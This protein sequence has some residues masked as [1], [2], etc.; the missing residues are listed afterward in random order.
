MRNWIRNKIHF[1]R[2]ILYLSIDTFW[3]ELCPSLEFGHTEET[4]SRSHSFKHCN[5]HKELEHLSVLCRSRQRIA[6]VTVQQLIQ[7]KK[8][9]KKTKR[10]RLKLLPLCLNCRR[11]FPVHWTSPSAF[12]SLACR[13]CWFLAAVACSTCIQPPF[14]LDPTRGGI[15]SWTKTLHAYTPRERNRGPRNNKPSTF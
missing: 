3:E 13:S 11:L 2:S 9:R 5:K 1:C 7:E 12:E 4:P 15:Q 6:S 14:Y 10:S 8:V